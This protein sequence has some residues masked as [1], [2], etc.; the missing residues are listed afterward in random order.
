MEYIKSEHLLPFG[1]MSLKRI[2]SEE[3]IFTGN[4]VTLSPFPL[5]KKVAAFTTICS[6]FGLVSLFNDI[7]TFVGYLMSKPFL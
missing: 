7:T 1:D 3:Y 6:V 2:H 4:P 5:V